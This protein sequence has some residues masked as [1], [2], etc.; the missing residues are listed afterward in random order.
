MKNFVIFD[1]ETTGFKPDDGARLIEL[2]LV[3]MNSEGEILDTWSTLINPGSDEPIHAQ[4][5][6]HITPADLIDA[7]TFKDIYGDIASFIGNHMLVAHNTPFDISFL[8]AESNLAGLLWPDLVLGDTLKAA[9]EL[10]P[11]LPSYKLGELAKHF[12][13]DFD[14]HAHAALADTLVTAKLFSHLLKL[15]EGLTWP[16]EYENFWSHKEKTGLI[17]SR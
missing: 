6:H 14:G 8:K 4:E 12:E 7:P 16:D 13:I 11:G 15:R 2:A 1:T 17:K 5:I 3:K 10:L 9:R